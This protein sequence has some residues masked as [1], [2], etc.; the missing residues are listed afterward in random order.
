M[1]MRPTRFVDAKE[2]E[3]TEKKKEPLSLMAA[4]GGG[5]RRRRALA[6]AVSLRLDCHFQ[7]SLIGQK[8]PKPPRHLHL[9]PHGQASSNEI[10]NYSGFPI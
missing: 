4:A 8:A 10:L 6:A 3:G 2:K 1:M 5:R 9:L 7:R